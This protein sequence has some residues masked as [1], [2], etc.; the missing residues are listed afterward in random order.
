MMEISQHQALDQEILSDPGQVA[1]FDVV[2]YVYDSSDPNSFG[3]IANLRQKFGVMSNIPSIFVAS[4]SDLDRVS[5]RY[6][7]QPD[8]YCRQLALPAPVFV[9][10]KDGVLADLFQ[11]IVAAAMDPSMALPAPFADKYRRQIVAASGIAGASLVVLAAS[12]LVYRLTRK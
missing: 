2:C 9:S 4:K 5:Q 10:A 11:T 3:Y 1:S 7:V 12:I 8:V 6:E